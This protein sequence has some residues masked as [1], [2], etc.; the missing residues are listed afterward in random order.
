MS[1]AYCMT[2]GLSLT[3]QLFMVNSFMNL[4]TF[5][6]YLYYC[7]WK[8]VFHFLDDSREKQR[9]TANIVTL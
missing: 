5:D 9:H 8:I 4:W 6:I 1:K 7:V 2:E 3:P